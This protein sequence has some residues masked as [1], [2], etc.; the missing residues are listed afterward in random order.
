MTVKSRS[1]Q[2]AIPCTLLLG[3]SVSRPRNQVVSLRLH[4]E[5]DDLLVQHLVVLEV[6]QQSRRRAPADRCTCTATPYAAASRL[7]DRKPSTSPMQLIIRI[8]LIAGT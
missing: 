2:I 3:I 1:R 7:E 8:Q 5:E 4:R 6:V